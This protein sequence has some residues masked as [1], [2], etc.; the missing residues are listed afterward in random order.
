LIKQLQ[1]LSGFSDSFGEIE[2]TIKNFSQTTDNLNLILTE[3]SSGNG[4]FNQLIFDDSI[5]KSL[6][7]ASENINLLLEDLRLN[8]KRYVHFSLFGKKDKPYE[9]KDE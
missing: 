1:I 4:T 7:A 6:N 9:N 3:I 2:K 5:I 8:P